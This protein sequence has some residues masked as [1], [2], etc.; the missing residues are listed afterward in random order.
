MREFVSAKQ[1]QVRGEDEWCQR[2]N[3]LEGNERVGNTQPNVP[4]INKALETMTT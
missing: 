1:D 2:T 4:R 3:G